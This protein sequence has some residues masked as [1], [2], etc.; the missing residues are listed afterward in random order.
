MSRKRS[1]RRW[2]TLTFCADALLLSLLLAGA[3]LSCQSAYPLG[4]NWGPLTLTGA[5]LGLIGL[6][7][8]VWFGITG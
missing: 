5:A 8:L 3:G 6:A 2:S 4:E 1:A 7:L